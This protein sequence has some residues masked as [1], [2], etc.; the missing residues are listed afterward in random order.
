LNELGK[1]ADIYIYPDTKHAFANPSGLAY[2]AGAA[3]QAWGRTIEF[4][5]ENLR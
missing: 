4:L 2:N 1:D 5:G 3:E